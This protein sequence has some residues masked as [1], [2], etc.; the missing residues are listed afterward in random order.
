MPRST[1]S[2][3]PG[4]NIPLLNSI[5]NVIVAEQLFDEQFKNERVAEWD[6]FCRVHQTIL[7]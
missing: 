1:C 3:D 2:H 6:E 5:A 7:A 4:T